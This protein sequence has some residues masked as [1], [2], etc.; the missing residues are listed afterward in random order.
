MQSSGYEP[1]LRSYGMAP[2]PYGMA[3][4]QVYMTWSSN[5]STATVQCKGPMRGKI[6]TCCDIGVK[7][8]SRRGSNPRSY[9]MAPRATALTTRPRLLTIQRVPAKQSLTCTKYR[10]SNCFHQ[11][12]EPRSARC[13]NKRTWPS[14]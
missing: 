11:L 2:I 12:F 14:G 6:P 10:Q 4:I 8:C 7:K 13:V 3:P 5:L 9:E 1:T